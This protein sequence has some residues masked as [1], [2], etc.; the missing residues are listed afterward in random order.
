MTGPRPSLFGLEYPRPENFNTS[1][2]APGDNTLT[3]PA[4]GLCGGRTRV[5]TD[6]PGATRFILPG[7]AHCHDIMCFVLHKFPLSGRAVDRYQ[8][9]AR[10]SQTVPDATI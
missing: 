10:L 8:V 7:Q 3:L 6:L 9:F 5:A 4:S 2:G 1:K